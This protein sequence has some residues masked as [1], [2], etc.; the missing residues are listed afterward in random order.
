MQ[1]AFPEATFAR[2]TLYLDVADQTRVGEL[3]D[4]AFDR[5]VV[6]VYDAL[7]EGK[8]VGVAY[9]DTQRVRTLPQTALVAVSPEGTILTVTVIDFREPREYLPRDGWFRQFDGRALD[10]ELAL[11]RGI[12]GV[13][14]ATLTSRATVNAAR[15]ALALHGL[16]P[17]DTP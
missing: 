7:R 11:R 6:S 12:N 8:A 14:G 15:R 10:R 16:H 4:A 1:A 3:A 9:L 17:P 13:T 2:R 5:G